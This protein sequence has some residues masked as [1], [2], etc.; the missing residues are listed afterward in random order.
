MMRLIY[1]EFIKLRSFG[2]FWVM[3]LLYTVLFS[4]A[5]LVGTQIN[6]EFPGISMSKLFQFP[7]LW[8]VTTWLASW[9]NLFLAI[10][11]ISLTCTEFQ[12][13]TYRQHRIDGLSIKEFIA[14]KLLTSGALAILAGLVVFAAT[15][16]T[17]LFMAGESWVLYF[18]KMHY[19][20]VYIIQ[21]AGYMAA[22][23]FTAIIIRQA[24]LSIVLFLSYFLLIESIFRIPFPD[25]ICAFFPAKVISNLTPPPDILEVSGTQQVFTQFNGQFHTYTP[26]PPFELGLWENMIVAGIWILAFVIASFAILRKS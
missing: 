18:D 16:V 10:L 2:P 6:L 23:L 4:A 8:N 5:L 12:N 17:G 11:I 1:I 26:P 14:G 3:I 9:F 25:E 7:H 24:A 13:K 21:A 19:L 15:L 20:F 22:G